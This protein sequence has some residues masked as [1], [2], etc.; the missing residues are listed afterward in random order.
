MSLDAASMR[1]KRRDITKSPLSSK[2]MMAHRRICGVCAHFDGQ[3]RETGR[4][5]R[6]QVPVRGPAKAWKCDA[7]TRKT[8]CQHGH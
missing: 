6:F 3:M 4:C 2:C 7:W 8:A 5:T 1:F